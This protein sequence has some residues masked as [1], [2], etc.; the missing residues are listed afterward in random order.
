LT[1][2]WALACGR[3]DVD[4]DALRQRARSAIKALHALSRLVPVAGPARWLHAGRLADA[5]VKSDR[6]LKA[7]QRAL[8]EAEKFR[9][10]R[11]TG[12]AC[13][14]LGL[15][16]DVPSAERMAYLG[17]AAAV[18]GEL[19][20]TRLQRRAGEAIQGEEGRLER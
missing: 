13:L 19:G 4:A 11:E 1:D 3:G 7:W 8:A 12:L 9:M 2:E 5:E 18:F 20:L 15:A 17:R 10:P 16:T 14:E 6:A